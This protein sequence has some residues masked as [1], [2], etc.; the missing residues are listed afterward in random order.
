MPEAT[1]LHIQTRDSAPTR[2]L[3]IPGASVRIG[4]GEQCEVRLGE[5]TLAEV[6]CMLRKRGETWHIQPVGPPGRVSIDGRAVEQPRPLPLG[7]VVRVGDHWLTLRPAEPA[8]FEG[9]GSYAPHEHSGFA[10]DRGPATTF[11]ARGE[12]TAVADAERDRLRRWQ[13]RQ[14]QR[15]R[16]LKARKEERRWEARWRAAGENLRSRTAP[17]AAPSP[18]PPSA[19]ETLPEPAPTPAAP[20][21]AVEPEIHAVA[22]PVEVA[23]EP[24]I[25]AVVEVP[26]V[27][28]PAAVLPEVVAL[29]DEPAEVCVP[30]EVVAE[31][32]T[33]EVVRPVVE[34]PVARVAAVEVDTPT[35]VSTEAEASSAKEKEESSEV[36]PKRRRVATLGVT[37]DP[38]AVPEVEAPALSAAPVVDGSIWE[39]LLQLLNSTDPG[40]P[41]FVPPPLLT[42][43]GFGPIPA[44]AEAQG[45]AATALLESLAGEF[46]GEAG[47]FSEAAPIEG[48]AAS[49]QQAEAVEEWPSARIILQQVRQAP[50]PRAVASSKKARRPA[51]SPMPTEARPPGQWAVPGFRWLWAPSIGAALLGGVVSVGMAANWAG[52]DQ[53]AG[54]AADRLLGREAAIAPDEARALLAA[55]GGH[56]EWWRTTAGHLLWR[57]AIADRAGEEGR[58]ESLTLLQAAR[59]AS[60]AHAG[61]RLALARR[62]AG[63]EALAKSLGLGRDVLA[64]AWT[65]RRLLEAGKVDAALRAYRS[66]LEMAERAEPEDSQA[67]GDQ[68]ARRFALPGEELIASVVRDMA[69][70]PE[71]TFERWASA[72]P[73]SGVG[74]LV[75]A[76]IL[77]EKASP[78]ADRAIEAALASAGPGGLGSAAKAEALAL[79]DRWEEAEAEYR[80]AI[81][82]ATDARAR[83][84]WSFNLSDIYAHLNDD[85][86]RRAAWADAKGVGPEDEITRRVAAAKAQAGLVGE[87]SAIADTRP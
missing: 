35:D 75:A 56:S 84:A 46:A 64:Q 8:S 32:T 43:S 67:R 50:R 30:P 69:E 28:E 44:M 79:N 19:F 66:A 61:V 65:G 59:G 26:A 54:L 57:A 2:V 38:A 16:W 71:W 83:R 41:V 58:S 53:A 60:P 36:R 20:T 39:G 52:D 14:E 51:R 47:A 80:R 1:F 12:S 11:A 86:K 5:P 55:S 13:E 81:E 40:K 25:V 15:D 37:V 48:L 34:E 21:P 3:E 73:T 76:R 22:I 77:K 7:V 18:A 10:G 33:I 72:L 9:W 82:A 63:P 45:G 17:Q 27:E 24:Q 42:P 29:A 4:R 49:A 62:E 68:P 87:T 6:Q 23:P 74:G 31:P 78:D 70:R 85:T